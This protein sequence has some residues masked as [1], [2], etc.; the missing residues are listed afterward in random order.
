MRP[1]I[2]MSTGRASVREL[3]SLTAFHINPEDPA[4]NLEAYAFRPVSGIDVKSR[5]PIPEPLRRLRRAVSSDQRI[6]ESA[7]EQVYPLAT[8]D[9]VDHQ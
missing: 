6:G 9:R 4:V 1:L 5:K 3:S 7:G 2:A 8:A